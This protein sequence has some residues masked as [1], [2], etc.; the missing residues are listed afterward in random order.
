MTRL[1]LSRKDFLSRS[2]VSGCDVD[3]NLWPYVCVYVTL[4]HNDFVDGVMSF[5]STM[6]L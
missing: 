1:N 2:L 4:L 3:E 6:Q 5:E